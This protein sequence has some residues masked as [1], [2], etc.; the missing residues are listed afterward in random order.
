MLE[1]RSTSYEEAA[2]EY[3]KNNPK[4]VHYWMTGEFE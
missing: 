2:E 4:R 3:I 1:A